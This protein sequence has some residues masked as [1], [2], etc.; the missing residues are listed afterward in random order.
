M[1]L[2]DGKKNIEIKLQI[3]NGAGYDPDISNEFFEACSL[4][5]DEEND[6]YIVDDV[7]YCIDYANDWK[8][9]K[10]DFYG[11]DIDNRNVDI[12]VL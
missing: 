10:G 2:S 8:N 9:G 3:W 12:T 11:D 4:P 7:D 1:K 5:Y 6:T